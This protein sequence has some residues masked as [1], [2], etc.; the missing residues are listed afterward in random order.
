MDAENRRF[1]D[2]QKNLRESERTI[3][4]L[5]YQQDEDRKNPDR[6]S[7][8]IHH[9]VGFPWNS[10]DYLTTAILGPRGLIY[11]KQPYHPV[12]PTIR[13]QIHTTNINPNVETI[14]EDLHKAEAFFASL[15][16]R[17]KNNVDTSFSH[18]KLP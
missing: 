4:E 11:Q 15:E 1:A 7:I 17:D 13:R 14:T 8:S 3:E 2:A 6:S 12:Y 9:S 10:T 18:T 5:S 16:N